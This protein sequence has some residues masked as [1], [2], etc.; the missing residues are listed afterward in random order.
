MR[1]WD[2]KK[3]VVPKIYV[4]GIEGVRFKRVIMDESATDRSPHPPE[5]PA[6]KRLIF[7]SGKVCTRHRFTLP[8]HSCAPQLKTAV[9][10]SVHASTLA[11]I[12]G[13]YT[14]IEDQLL[15]PLEQLPLR[16]TNW[17]SVEL[18]RFCKQAGWQLLGFQRLLALSGSSEVSRHYGWVV[19]TPGACSGAAVLRAGGGAG[20]AGEAGRDRHCAPGAAGAL[21]L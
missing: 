18:Y 2:V 17:W 15:S 8:Q 13:G 19:V 4:Q 7:C 9:C 16:D 21:P 20:E 14:C 12:A 11:N 5:E 3:L 1:F 6:F 10:G